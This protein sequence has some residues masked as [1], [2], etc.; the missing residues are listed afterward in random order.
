[1]TIDEYIR[2]VTVLYL[3]DKF[4]HKIDNN[5]FHILGNVGELYL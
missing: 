1:M 4:I 2:D 3:Q 5:T